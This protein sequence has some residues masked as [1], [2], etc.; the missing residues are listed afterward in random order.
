MKFN[1]IIKALR[2]D[3]DLTQSELAKE[4]NVNQITISQYERGTRQISLDMLI[5]Y[6]K[7][8]NVSTDYI[9][10]LTKNPTPNYDIKNQLNISDQNKIHKIEMKWGINMEQTTIADYNEQIQQAFSDGLNSGLSQGFEII[11]PYVIGA[12]VIVLIGTIIKA[13]FK[14]STKRK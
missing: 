12:V 9:L 8:F 11:M 2:E 3:A 4:F 7:K 1:E 10:G 13:L 14:K 5:N 6:A